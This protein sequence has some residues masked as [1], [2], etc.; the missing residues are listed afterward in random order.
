ME[1]DSGEKEGLDV[2]SA[3]VFYA[4]SQD[5]I[6]FILLP[7]QILKLIPFIIKLSRFIQVHILTVRDAPILRLHIGIG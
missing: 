3:R 5:E 1:E 4:G 7:S 2:T 6:T